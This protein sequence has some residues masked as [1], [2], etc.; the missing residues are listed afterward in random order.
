MPTDGTHFLN[1]DETFTESTRGQLFARLLDLAFPMVEHYKGD[2]YSDALWLGKYVDGPTV[3]FY[4]VRETGTH[5]G[6]D[7]DLIMPYNRV[8]YR[9]EVKRERTAWVADISEVVA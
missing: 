3:F 8:T 7:G 5:I 2:L 4:G 6:T 1:T 9:V